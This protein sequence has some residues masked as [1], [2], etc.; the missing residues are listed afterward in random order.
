MDII[1][2]VKVTH[3]GELDML[4]IPSA[5]QARFEEC[6]R[7]NAVPKQT[8]GLYK[9]WLRYYLDFCQKYDFPDAQR[10]ILPAFLCN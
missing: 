4:R 1:R 8:H 9:K 7:N 3:Y 10:E 6:L 2:Y 5:L